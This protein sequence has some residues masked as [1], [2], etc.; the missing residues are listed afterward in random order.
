MLIAMQIRWTE[1]ILGS[2]VMIKAI[3]AN[4][5]VWADLDYDLVVSFI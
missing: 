4:S 3:R 2:I 5:V 1:G